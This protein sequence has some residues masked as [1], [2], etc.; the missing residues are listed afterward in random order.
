L[1]DVGT[2]R[3]QRPAAFNL[4]A[5]HFSTS[6]SRWS[7]LS[8]R[9][10]FSYFIQQSVLAFSRVTAGSGAGLA[11]GVGVLLATISGVGELIIGCLGEQAD[12]ITISIA[13]ST[14]GM[15]SKKLPERH[16]GISP[17]DMAA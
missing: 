3:A 13:H 12:A 1:G 11:A 8:A 16:L 5:V 9:P 10:S 14:I 2:A 15:M 6:G 17:P 7:R 4:S